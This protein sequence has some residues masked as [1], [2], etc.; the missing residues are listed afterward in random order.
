MIRE[1]NEHEI[2][3][4]HYELLLKDILAMAERLPPFSDVV[5]KVMPLIRKMA[6][7]K[8]IEAVIKYDQAIAARV[9]A[10]SQSSFYGRRS[11]V[12]SLQDAIRVLGEHKL[13]QVIMTALNRGDRNTHTS[14]L[15]DRGKNIFKFFQVSMTRGVSFS[16]MALTGQTSTQARHSLHE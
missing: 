15:S 16:R 3:A 1:L 6:P 12:S 5:W 8:E 11:K 4:L 13:V 2:R 14:I 9:L 10:L 7:I